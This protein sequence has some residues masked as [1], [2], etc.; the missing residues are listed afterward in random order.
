LDFYP[1]VAYYNIFTNICQGKNAVFL[2]KMWI[3]AT[4]GHRLARI[5]LD[6]DRAAPLGVPEGITQRFRHDYRI[7]WKSFGEGVCDA[8]VYSGSSSPEASFIEL[9]TLH[10]LPFGRA[11]KPKFPLQ[12]CLNKPYNSTTALSELRFKAGVPLFTL[13]NTD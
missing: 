4:D 13:I 9:W 1:T 2:K 10:P 7:N 6:S 8:Y 3:V 11:S 5:N 12:R